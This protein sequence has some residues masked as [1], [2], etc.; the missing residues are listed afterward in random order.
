MIEKVIKFSEENDLPYGVGLL[1]NLPYPILEKVQGREWNPK[2]ITTEKGL[3]NWCQIHLRV[4]ING[5]ITTLV[6]DKGYRVI[7]LEWR[8]Y[9]TDS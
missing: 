9:E 5:E 1:H 6:D 4:N 8:D 3:V 7:S 2:Y